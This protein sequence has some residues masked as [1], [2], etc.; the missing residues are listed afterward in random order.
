M[1]GWYFDPQSGGQ[2]IPAEVQEQMRSR[3]L[4]YVEQTRPKRNWQLRIRFQK[5]FCYLDADEPDSEIP[6]HLC[7]LRYFGNE[8]WSLAFYTY[9]NERYQSCVFKSGE[10]YGSIEEAFETSAVYL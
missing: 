1:E 2:I 10:W 6:T 4:R 3:I 8:R 9:S 5:Q 7:R